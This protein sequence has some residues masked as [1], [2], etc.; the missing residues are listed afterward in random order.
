MSETRLS[1]LTATGRKG[2]T[3]FNLLGSAA[4]GGAIPFAGLASAQPEAG[5]VARHAHRRL[6]RPMASACITG[7]LVAASAAA[8]FVL[9]GA[10][11]RSLIP[12]TQSQAGGSQ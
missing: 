7:G 4:A 5:K 11:P 3:S 2:G 8:V 6:S 10:G 12:Q 9:T 1:S